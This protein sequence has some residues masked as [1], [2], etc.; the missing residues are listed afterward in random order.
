MKKTTQNPYDSFTDKGFID[1]MN[2]AFP[3]G[4]LADTQ[5][6][7]KDMH[8]EYKIK[9]KVSSRDVKYG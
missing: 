4:P 7:S 3:N 1:C 6:P 2:S 5:V 8:M 9:R